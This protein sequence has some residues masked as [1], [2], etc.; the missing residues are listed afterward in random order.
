MYFQQGFGNASLLFTV[1]FKMVNFISLLTESV[2][3]YH[4]TLTS[5]M[6]RRTELFCFGLE[7]K[8][9][10]TFFSSSFLMKHGAVYAAYKAYLRFF[11]RVLLVV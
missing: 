1:E 4:V 7:V 8:T 2:C 11:N 3:V 6:L 10:V 9:K 5:Q